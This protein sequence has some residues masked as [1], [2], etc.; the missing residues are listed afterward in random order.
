[1]ALGF[2]PAG[3]LVVAAPPDPPGVRALRTQVLIATAWVVPAGVRL[4]PCGSTQ[5]RATSS[6]CCRPCCSGVGSRYL[7]SIGA[8]ATFGLADHEQGLA[9]GRVNAASNRGSGGSRRDLGDPRHAS[10]SEG[11]GAGVGESLMPD[12]LTGLKVIAGSSPAF[13]SWALHRHA[14]SCGTPSS[15]RGG[16]RCPRRRRAFHDS[17]Q[18]P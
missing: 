3:L 8:Q 12:M 4:C 17:E 10:A 9:S 2:L 15:C 6:C 1:M 13:G 5:A 18:W 16:G 7:P 11:L 14:S